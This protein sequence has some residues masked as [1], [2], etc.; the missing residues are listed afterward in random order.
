MFRMFECLSTF[1]SFLPKQYA[2]R[3]QYFYNDVPTFYNYR[4]F[5]K[6][7]KNGERVQMAL[8]IGHNKYFITDQ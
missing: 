1:K 8:I 7:G 2:W 3:K 6:L 4:I 5:F